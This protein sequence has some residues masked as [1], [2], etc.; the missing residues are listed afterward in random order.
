MLKLVCAIRALKQ[1]VI[2]PLETYSPVGDIGQKD[3]KIGMLS[4]LG[5]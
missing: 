4:I 2:C 1:A 3:R 5:Y